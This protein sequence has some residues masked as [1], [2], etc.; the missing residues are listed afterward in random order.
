MGSNLS[1]NRV[2]TKDIKSTYYCNVRCVNLILSLVR[3]PWLKTG[4]SHNNVKFRLLDK[5]REMK[6]LVVPWDLVS[7]KRSYYNMTQYPQPY[8]DSVLFQ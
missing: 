4:E 3:M 1:L 7:R 2:M 8:G 5:D 6:W